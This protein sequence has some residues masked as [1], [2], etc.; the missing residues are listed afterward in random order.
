MCQQNFEL[1]S[2]KKGRWCQTNYGGRTGWIFDAYVR[3]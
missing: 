1:I 3:Y 2:G